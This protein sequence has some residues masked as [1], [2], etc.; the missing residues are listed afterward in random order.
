VTTPGRIGGRTVFD[1]RVFRLDVDRVRY[2]DGSEGDLDVVRHPGASAIV[3]FLSDPR[4]DDPQLLLLKQYRYAANDVLYEIPAGRLHPGEDP[5]QA[6]AREVREETGCTAAH[7]A[8]LFTVFTTPGFTDELLHV[9]LATGLA[10][11][12]TEGRDPD[13]FIEV[14]TVTLSQALAMVRDGT[15]RDMKTVAALLYVAGFV[16][17]R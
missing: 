6:A 14:E 7:L 12:T 11:A 4:G 5:A 1:G 17:G 13:E 10:Q 3:P 8:H 9:Y 2:P 15:I 16:A